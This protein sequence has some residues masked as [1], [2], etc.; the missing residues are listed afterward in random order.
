VTLHDLIELLKRV[1]WSEL[2]HFAWLHNLV[3][4]LLSG[5]GL[6]TGAWVKRRRA[7]LA[8][9]WPVVD[10]KVGAINVV[11]TTQF[12]GSARKFTAAFKYSYR[13]RD[14]EESTYYSGDYARPFPNDDIA[15]E[16]VETLK[17]KQIRVHVSPEH[18]EI[19]AVLTGDLDAHFPLPMRSPADLVMPPSGLQQD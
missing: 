3:V 6:G 11:R 16:W 2:R 1:H 7:R 19:S 9:N 8:Q 18:P 4:P 5:G 10:G 15:W 17:G 13:V 14:G 12:H